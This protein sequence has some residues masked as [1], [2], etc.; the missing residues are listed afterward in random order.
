MV[1]F[2][3]LGDITVSSA[4]TPVQVSATQILTP[5]CAITAKATNTGNIYVFGSGQTSSAAGA[6]VRPGE[7]IE[8]TGP[9]IGGTEDEFDLSRIYIDA[10]TSGDKVT[11]AYFARRI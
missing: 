9:Q 10:A 2:K 1:D 7:S 6:E 5:G 8:I 11:V 3:G 4:G